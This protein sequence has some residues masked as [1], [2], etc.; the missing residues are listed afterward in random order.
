MKKQLMLSFVMALTFMATGSSWAKE[1][2]KSSAKSETAGCKNANHQIC[3]HTGTCMSP[4]TCQNHAPKPS[5]A[6]K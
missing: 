2:G 3:P 5:A 6:T 4:Q 1:V